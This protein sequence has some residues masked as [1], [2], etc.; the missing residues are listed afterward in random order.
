MK[1][2]N[3]D[4]DLNEWKLTDSQK[5]I[6]NSNMLPRMGGRDMEFFKKSIEK[7]ELNPNDFFNGLK[8]A[9]KILGEYDKGHYIQ[10]TK[11]N[12]DKMINKD[13]LENLPP[14]EKKQVYFGYYQH[15]LTIDECMKEK[16]QCFIHEN[17]W[18][19][20]LN[21][22]TYKWTL[23][24]K[25]AKWAVMDADEC[26]IHDKYYEYKKDDKWHYKNFDGSNY[27]GEKE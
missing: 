14:E 17:G 15:G 26:E 22:P 16:Y 11:I 10:Q 23:C 4:R 21:T 18:Y 2:K 7:G 9:I 1:R 12:K 5:K 20:Y 3:N 19:Y 13:V 25:D 24:R 27:Y 8:Q 6:L